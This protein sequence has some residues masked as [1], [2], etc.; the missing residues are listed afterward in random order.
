MN[1]R[2]LLRRLLDGS[3]NVSFTDMTNLAQG[4]GFRLA[5]VRGS[6]HIFVHPDIPELVNLQEIDGQTKPY[7]VRQF[8]KLV[9][10][11]D[12]HLEDEA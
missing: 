4:F 7:Q 5:R 10:R 9:E 3:L 1:R 8:L 12:L 6:H 2:R 11:H